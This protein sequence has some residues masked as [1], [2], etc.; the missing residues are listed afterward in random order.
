MSSPLNK[1]NMSC[2][3]FQAHLPEL[4]GS[5]ENVL[6]HPH[7]QT[8]ELCRALYAELEVIAQAARDLLATVEPPDDLW[9]NIESAIKG[10]DGGSHR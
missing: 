2:A 10:E 4:I 5:G 9:E 7:M 3:E 1:N 6:N 8:C